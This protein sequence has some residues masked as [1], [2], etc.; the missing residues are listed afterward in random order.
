MLVA[1]VAII[2]FIFVTYQPEKALGGAFTGTASNLKVA[3]TTTVGPQAVIRTQIFAAN[4]QCKARVITT[5]G[6][7]A[8]M[9]SFGEP[10]TPGNIS[11]TTLAGQVGHLQAASTTVEYDSEIYGCGLWRAYG[12]ASTTLTVSEFQ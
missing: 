7:S 11:S 8:I 12:Y 9:I 5:P 6:T 4:P 2:A 10:Q 1:I 3:T